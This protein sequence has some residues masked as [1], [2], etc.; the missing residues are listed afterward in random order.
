MNLIK[1]RQCSLCLYDESHP[2]GLV[3]DDDGICSGCRVHNEKYQIDWRSRKAHLA[4]IMEQARKQANG[5]HDCVIYVDSDAE[6]F[7]LVYLIKVVLGYEPLL[8]TFNDYFRTDV[9]HKNLN[10]LRTEFDCDL[11]N[12]TP[13][14]SQYKKIIKESFLKTGNFLWPIQAAKTAL[15]VS[16][17]V[18]KGIPLVI[19][20][21]HQGMEQTGMFSH[22]DYVNMSEWYRG[23]HDLFGFTLDEIVSGSSL[24]RKDQMTFYSYPDNKKIIKSNVKGIYLNNYFLWDPLR[25]NNQMIKHGYTPEHTS[26]TFDYFDRSGSSVYYNVHDISRKDRVGYYKVRDHLCREI[27]HS[28]I[29][30]DDAVRAEAYYSAAERDY[31]PFLKW[32]GFDDIGIDWISQR[33]LKNTNDIS[34]KT[35]YT[36]P[37]QLKALC[38]EPVIPDKTFLLFDK[39]LYLQSQL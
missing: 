15:P 3:I 33:Y 31:T 34:E 38:P 26:S 7:Y 11:L 13:K 10:T 8:V 4:N 30:R 14:L 35:H 20:G 18:N 25:Q 39:S 27:R 21:G 5:R 1:T 17:A 29:T 36:L 22:T 6:S 24:L 28:R 37:D 16:L 32:L 23:E 2:F 9:G 19:W 12:F